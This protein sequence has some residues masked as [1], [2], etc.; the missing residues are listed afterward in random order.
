LLLVSGSA[1]SKKP[2]ARSLPPHKP[3]DH[4]HQIKLADNGFKGR[5]PAG[6]LSEPSVSK[7]VLL[8]TIAFGE[9]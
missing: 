8:N 7:T 9:Y 3:G 5:E 4:H 6:P 2:V 1:R